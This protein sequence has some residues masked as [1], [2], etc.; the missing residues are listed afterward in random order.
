[1]IFFEHKLLY[2]SKGARKEAGGIEV[3]GHIPEEE[4][5]IPLGQAKIARPGRDITVVANLL[6][7]HR[8]LAA[9]AKLAR[10]ASGGSD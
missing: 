1:M 9:A 2:G 4:Y 8:S 5:L 6:M 3:V 10:Q 7:V